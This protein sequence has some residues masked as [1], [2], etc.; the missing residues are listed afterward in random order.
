MPAKAAHGVK[1]SV[2]LAALLLGSAAHAAVAETKVTAGQQGSVTA[3]AIHWTCSG[4]HCSTSALPLVT[5]APLTMCQELA[6]SV[7]AIRS[8]R[9]STSPLNGKELQ[10]C[11]AVVS[12]TAAGSVAATP[13]KKRPVPLVLT[14]ATLRYTGGTP[15]VL[16]TGTLRYTGGTPMVLTTG[17][18]LYTGR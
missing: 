14:T 16:T 5:G 3:G 2:S 7:G 11:N 12:G 17:T 6:R 8:F 18:L 9:A 13:G 15:M 1:W 4:T 10:Q